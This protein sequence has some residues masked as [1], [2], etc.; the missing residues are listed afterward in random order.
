MEDQLDS[1]G[2]AALSGAAQFLS[3]FASGETISRATSPGIPGSDAGD[4]TKRYRPRTFSYFDLLPYPVEEEAQRDAA[5][6]GILKQLYIAI[7]AEDFSPGAIHW[8]RQLQSW[9]SL[10][11]D[12]PRELRANLAQLYFHLS[13]AP[14]LDNS[15]AD[16]FSRMVSVLA[17]RKHLLKPIDDLT[18]DWKPIWKEIKSLVLPG[19]APAHHSSRRRGLKNMWRLCLQASI[20]IDPRERRAMLDEILPYFSTSDLQNA[21]IVVGALNILVPT[22]PCPPTEPQSQPSDFVPTFFHLWS[23]NTRSKVF[24][25]VFLDIFSRM[26]RDYLSCQHVPFSEHGIFAREQSDLIFTAIL[27]LTEIPVGQANSPYTNLD[28]SSGLGLLLEKDKKKYPISYTIARFIVSSLSPQCLDKNSSI[29]D[30][31]EGLMESID[32]FFHPSNQGAWTQMLAQLTFYLT[33]MFVS[34]WN[35]EQKSEQDTPADRRLN[36]D[37]KKRFVLSL[38][39]VTFMG[40]FGKST[41]VT[42]MYFGSLQNLTYLEPGLMLP[43]ALQ[44]FYPSLQGL[45]EVHRTTSSLCGLQMVANIMSKQK[46]F[47]CHLTALLA[48][49]LPG[50]DANDLN[51][52]QYTL[53]FIQSVAYS[54][55]FVNLTKANSDVHDTTLAMQ[56][57]QGEM[58]RMEREGQDVKID[59]EN[60]LSD[61]DEA[62]IVRSS[63]AGFGE[64]IISLLGK[65]F[66]LL[67]NLPDSSHLR[68][69]SPEDNIINTLPAALTPLFASLSP[70]LFEIVLDKLATFVSTHVVHQARDSMAW[71]CNALCKVNPEKT[72]KLFLPMLIVNIRNEIDYNG[73]ASD[74]SSG[75]EVLPRDRA[76]VWHVSIL[77]MCVV[78]VGGETLK[79]KK[80]LFEIAQYMQEKC[81]GLPT[82]HISNF[83]HHLLL[84]LTHTYPI[85]NALYE[86]DVIKRG[87]DVDDWGRATDPAN[88]TIKWHRATPEELQFAVE[89]FQAQAE[90]AMQRLESFMSDD[91]PVSRKGKNKEW[92][93]EVSRQLSQ[94]RLVI[95]GIATL[96]DPKRASGEVN[97]HVNGTTNTDAEGDDEMKDVDEEEDPLAEAG[98][99]DE[100]KPQYKYQSGYLLKPEDPL[101]SR[102]HDIRDNIGRLLS[103]THSFLNTHQADDVSCF[104]ALYSTY[105]MWITDVGFERSAHPLERLQRLYKADVGP[106]KISALRK[107]YPRPLLIKR[108]DAY[109]LQRA[110]HNASVRNKSDLDKRLLL[111]LAESCV[112]PY[113]D[114]RR[115]AQ[116]AQDASL[117]VLIGG[118]PLV[119]PVILDKFRKALAE[120]DHDRIKGSMYTLF[121]TSLLKTMMRDWRFAPDLMRLYIQAAGVDKTSIQNL[122]SSALYPMIEFGKRFELMVL[123]DDDI[124]SLIEP[125]E[126]CSKPITSRH[127][128]I[129]ERRK[130][131]EAR[132]AELGLELVK[133]AKGSHWKTASRCAIFATNLC[134]RFDTVAPPEFIELA[135]SGA[136]DQHPGLRSGFMTAFSNIFTV[137]DQRAVYNHSY[138]DFLEEKEKDSN[139]ITVTVPKGDVAYTEKFL[140]QFTHPQN[141]EYY[142]DTDHV[143][144]LVWGKKF[145]ASKAKPNRFDDYDD[146]EIAARKQIGELLTREWLAKCFEHMKQEPRDTSSDRFRSQNVILLMHVFDLMNYEQTAVKFE[147]VKELTLEI[148]GDGSDKHQHR[149][150][151]EIIGAMLAGSADDPID[152]RDR[153]W[154][155]AQPLMLKIFADNLTPEN[156]SYWSTCLHF[157][158]DTKDPRRAHELVES[159]SSFRLDMSSNAAF[160]E[161]S[162]VLLLEILINDCGWHFRREKPILEDFLAHIDHPY[163]SVRE[164]IGR[165]IATIYRTRYHES[166]ENV[167]ALLEKNKT[168]STIGIRPYR[169][170]EE[171]SSTMKEV[172]GRLEKWRH[173]REPG[174]QTPSSYTSGSKTVLTWL[175]ST[176]SSQEC[177]QL[178]SFFPDPFMDQLLHMMDVKEDPEL[179]RLAYHVYR[180]LPNIP[181][182]SGEDDAF[183][184]ALIRIGKSATSWHQRLRA[185]VNMQVIY[186]RRL[187]LT[188]P[189]QRELLFD[190]VGDMLADPQLEVR[191]VAGATLAGMIRCS[192][193]A[194]RN[195]IIK[196]L[197]K[198]FESQLAKNP[199][200]K[201]KLP[202]T[203]TPVNQTQQVVRRHAAVLGLGSLIEAFPYAT[204][205]PSWMPEVLA[206][207]ARKAASDPGVVGKATKSILSEFKKTRQD[208]WGVD[209]KYFTSEQLEDLE[210]V[211]WKSYFA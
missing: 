106:F 148:Y 11:F 137:I 21:Y 45:V 101:Y 177:T 93:D 53:N 168:E 169:P 139:K 113:A 12:M 35:K 97:G 72:L 119:I 18:L 184:N 180:H 94:I 20:Y 118:R 74:R 147:D 191:T 185:L 52:T 111:D 153:A 164:S 124:V 206:L 104:T 207:L 107:A 109:H 208:S 178:V 43:G 157:I 31:L 88:L 170:S 112:S 1:I 198:R 145:S 28:Y 17:K 131:V 163:K 25:N 26:A 40:L 103:R 41:K 48:L 14:G 105:R 100:T 199:M 36:D 125:S 96:F 171:F 158:I 127:N 136:N 183:I 202:G 142:V 102:I 195:P 138:R 193:A 91:A 161:S 210:G 133:I 143:G 144:W 200:P 128:F 8:T 188:G 68:T 203:D 123:L 132:K 181:F 110:K 23:L 84:N 173:E 77:S 155:F 67:E 66:T 87:L 29:L 154:G 34:R 146:V 149:A 46:G 82:L 140:D 15:S 32:T 204:P 3:T 201:K 186:F 56:W 42:N 174:Q 167:S 27:R 10:K 209:Q 5:L 99:D 98:E 7:K 117:K 211:L 176:L 121:F 6:Q 85:D 80:E 64:F 190:A 75:T 37:L 92:S 130:K 182:R 86:P 57:V 89:V 90:G 39:E 160:K 197:K 134:L 166:F 83:I 24:D 49:A 95:S 122:G 79:Y 162:K 60:E 70:E 76:L 172:F 189:N 61:E 187:F 73:A 4:D 55:P 78:H 165:V 115:V 50:I 108:A 63:T 116:G 192:P 38:R 19:E 205:P 2:G 141:A 81:R 151:A 194:I 59:Y 47:R 175:D 30:S 65:V 58:E 71:I 13:L 33:E 196:I 135:V 150:T 120:V 51:K 129:L 16:R 156:L 126:D 114:V 22:T 152:M 62:S 69:G 9:L 179:M 159:L 54:I 44:R